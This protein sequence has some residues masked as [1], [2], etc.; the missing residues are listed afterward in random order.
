MASKSTQKLNDALLDKARASAEVSYLA[1]AVTGGGFAIN[2]F[3]QLFLSAFKLGKKKP[4]DWAAYAWQV[5]SLQ[6]QK[7][8]VDGNTLQTNEE[9]L[10]ELTRQAAEFGQKKLPVLKALQ[11]V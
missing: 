9:N 8:V 11:V 3:Q 1:S 10:K 2:R 4:E 6:G 7:L 5:L